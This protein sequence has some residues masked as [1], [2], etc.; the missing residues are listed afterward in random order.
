MNVNLVE[1]YGEEGQY[2]QQACAELYVLCLD[3]KIHSLSIGQQFALSRL[4][5][6]K[7]HSLYHSFGIVLTSASTDINKV[8][9]AQSAQGQQQ[10]L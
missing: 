4:S 5:D 2:T 6:P 10:P 7:V 3:L 8:L 9:S 1:E